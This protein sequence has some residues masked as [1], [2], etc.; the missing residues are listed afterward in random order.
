MPKLAAALVMIAALG[1]GQLAAADVRDENLPL[2]D[3][4][5]ELLAEGV[6]EYLTGRPEQAAKVFQSVLALE[7]DNRLLYEFYLAV[8]DQ[9]LMKM[10]ELD[11]LDDVLKELLRRARIYQKELRHSPEFINLMIS[12]LEKS[13]EERVVATNELV[14]IGPLA[15]PHL[16]AKIAD[17]RQ[18]MLRVYS[19]IALTK[20][21]YRAVVPL[22]EALNAQ[23]QRLV[24]S[25]A[26]V[27]A[28]I[29]DPRPLAKLKL[30]GE[31]S[32]DDATK[33]VVANTVAAINR[34][35]GIEPQPV[36]AP[37]P[38]PVDPKAKKKDKGEPAAE[39]AP[40]PIPGPTAQELGA[41]KLYF[42][43]AMRYFRGDSRVQ[44]EVVA[45]EA[46]MWRWNE[47]AA[48]TA[49]KLGFVRVP[50]YAWNE[51][52]AEELVFDGMAAYP[53]FTAYQPL[54][55]ASLQAQ[56][57]E[58]QR[59][60]RLAKERTTPVQNPEDS[61]DAIAERLKA[62]E[63]ISLRVRMQGPSHLYRGVQQAI[64]AE[65]YDVAVA[66]MRLLQDV[67]TA[68]ADRLL[69][70]R[71][72][73]LGS[74]KPGTVLVA[75]LDHA[76]KTVRYQAA[77]TLAHLDPSLKFFNAE[78]VV[79]LLADAVG[80]W[81]MRVV[82]VVDQ[83][84][85]QRNTAREQLQKQGYLVY[86]AE[87]GF[88][89]MQR[90][91]ESPIKDAIIIAGDLLPTYR[92]E[93]G[94]LIDVPEQKAE[95]LVEQLKK[96]WRAEK[97]PVFIS[98][99]ERGETAAKIQTALDGKVAG[100]VQKPFAGADIKG[101]I[102][103]A[104]ATAE[105]PNVNRET[106]EEVSLRAA[107]ALAQPDPARTQF[108]LAQAAEAL[109]KTL[110]ARADDLRIAALTALG[111]AA[112]QP[113]AGDAV[114]GLVTKVIDVY[115][116]QD[117]QLTPA[118]RAAFLYAIGQLDPADPAAAPVLKA[119]LKHDDLAVRTAAADAVAHGAAMPNEL[120]IQL[121]QQQRLDARA[122]GNGQPAAAA[123]A[124]ATPQ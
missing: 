91:E 67:Y 5:R 13:E 79:P 68:D 30:I 117:A 22:T 115:T 38:K 99:P 80:E 12:K 36:Q 24:Q 57:V 2:N 55:A 58:A 26:M 1:S 108:T 82:V 97:T 29:G 84:Y 52:M 43:E 122:P 50:A 112:Q 110:D 73:G 41:D 93:F 90:L 47:E 87:N 98:L 102:E 3:Q 106:A 116:A 118:V 46:L 11:Q 39:P 109:V 94:G 96:D 33:R 53:A 107:R 65:R 95:T 89:L 45:N 20:M 123:P 75:A 121:Q 10:M 124:A 104:L 62:V 8:G 32:T 70:S 17:N 51:L 119:A 37:A 31:T 114:K 92:D 88:D 40:T 105:L 54:L 113:K 6:K 64:V 63:E 27:L 18:D 111:V 4:A 9:R 23:D 101:R 85:R 69:P 77:A 103:A 34:K 71:E 78:K 35:T 76:D 48:D 21:G 66:L 16:V 15:V 72:E 42:L 49:T 74:D 28:D 19:R 100:F 81:G 60:A 56:E 83:D 25:V 14:A 86:T 61:A 7:P 44:D 59:R 120:L